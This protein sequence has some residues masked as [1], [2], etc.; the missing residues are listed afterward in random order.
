M[1]SSNV[2]QQKSLPKQYLEIIAAVSS[3]WVCSIG[4]VFLNKHLLSSPDLKVNFSDFPILFLNGFSWTP[5]FSSHGSNAWS[6]SCCAIAVP[7]FPT[8]F[9]R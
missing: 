8:G 3:Y 6:P 5:H 1:S 9:R 2:Q 4:L 7:S